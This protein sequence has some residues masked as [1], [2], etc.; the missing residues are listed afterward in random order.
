MGNAAVAPL[1]TDKERITGLTFPI[2]KDTDNK[3]ADAFA[4]ERTP[5][6]FVLDAQRAG[7]RVG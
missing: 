5:E 1:A 7:K 6:V 3:I 4:A 2:L